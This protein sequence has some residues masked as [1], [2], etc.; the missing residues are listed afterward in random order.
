MPRTHPPYPA[1][2]KAAAVQLARSGEKTIPA[3]AADLGVSSEALRSW[4]LQAEADAGRGQAGDLTTDEREE[5]R[6][7]RRKNHVLKQEREIL[8]KAAAWGSREPLPIYPRGA[9]HLSGRPAVPGAAR[10]PLGVL[11]LGTLRGLGPHPVRRAASGAARRRLRPQPPDLRRA[12]RPR[13]V[14]RGGRA[15]RP[16]AG[17][18]PH[19]R[20]RARRL[21]PTAGAHDGRR[22]GAHARAE[23]GRPR[24]RGGGAEPPLERRQ[25]VSADPGGLVVPRRAARCPLPARGRLGDGRPPTYRTRARCPRDGPPSSPTDPGQRARQRGWRS[26][27]G[28]RSGTTVSVAT[29]PWPTA[30]PSPMRSTCCCC[31]IWPLSVTLSAKTALPQRA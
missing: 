5:R 2:F 27:S 7:L 9:G 12:A 16:Q 30:A 13:R 22:P 26:S 6:R 20:R 11:Y 28:S 21:P 23:P 24:L 19:A 25:H 4:L 17:R 18:P 8:K 1:E 10:R 3:L 15:L 14:A 29:P 31:R